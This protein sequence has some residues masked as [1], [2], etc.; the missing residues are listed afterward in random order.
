[1][2]VWLEPGLPRFLL[3][4]TLAATVIGMIG[5]LACLTLN[6]ID[7]LSHRSTGVELRMS[8]IKACL[9]ALLIV[10]PLT[11]LNLQS[12]ASGIQLPSIADFPKQEE[13]AAQTVLQRSVQVEAATVAAPPQ[14]PRKAATP[15]LTPTSVGVAWVLI[16]LA[17]LARIG[18]RRIALRRWLAGSG[19]SL[20]PIVEGKF[21][22]A[23]YEA[24]IAAPFCTGLWRPFIVLP[25]DFGDLPEMERRS[26]M[27][28]EVA[29]ITLGHPLDRFFSE[30]ASAFFGWIPFVSYLCRQLAEAQEQQCDEVVFRL[31]GGGLGLAQGLLRFAERVG[32]RTEPHA[33]LTIVRRRSGIEARIRRLTQPGGLSMPLN[34]HFVSLSMSAVLAIVSMTALAVQLKD[35]P[36]DTVLQFMPFKPGTVWTYRTTY[37]SK[38]EKPEKYRLVALGLKPNK[39]FPVMEFRRKYPRD[40]RYE[41]WMATPDGLRPVDSR[42]MGQEPG[43]DTHRARA[44]R[45]PVPFREGYTWEWSE[46]FRG[47][48]MM[49]PDGKPPVIPDTKFWGRVTAVDKPIVVKAGKFSTVVT[50]IRADGPMGYGTTRYYWAKNVGLIKLE[51]IDSNGQYSRTEELVSVST[52]K[53]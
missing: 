32:S 46:E 22:I 48:T 45:L 16:S 11:S 47:Q 23:L 9:V 37:E 3:N 31:E 26:V 18:V 51:Y 6:A 19:R 8:A 7:R 29:H 25:T 4:A 40:A 50:E 14:E 1:M 12:G 17:C 49:G 15:L 28:H 35:S 41:Y 5:W 20:S 38:A 44:P 21:K 10:P 27:A 52:G 33:V 2:S 30:V 24:K 53:G 39:P 13:A 43:F 36:T 34:K 42:H